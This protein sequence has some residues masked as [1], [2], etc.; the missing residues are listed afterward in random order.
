MP[1]GCVLSL[2]LYTL[3]THNCVPTHHSNKIIKFTD[4][5]VVVRFILRKEGLSDGSGLLPDG[6]LNASVGGTVTFRTNLDPTE[7]PLPFINWQFD[8]GP[9]LKPVLLLLTT[10]NTTAPE[11]EGRI[12]VFRSTGSLELRNLKL[13]DSGDYIVNIQPDGKLQVA[14]RTTLHIY[15]PVSSVSL[16]STSTDLIEF[17]SSVSLSCSSSGS[18]VSFLWMNSSSEVTASDR[19]QITDGGSTLTIVSVTRYD[20]GPYSC[21]VSNP[22][23]SIISDPVNFSVSYG[24]DDIQIEVAPPNEHHKKGSDIILTCSA[25]SSP[26]AEFLWFLN[27]GQMPDTGPE[28]KLMNIQMSQSG[29]YSCQAFNN[30]TLSYQ[31]SQPTAIFVHEPVFNVK[32]TQEVTHLIEFRGSVSFFCSSSG[33]SLSFLWMNSS[34]EVTASDRVQIT[35]GGSTLTIVNV[36]RD[37]QG[38]YSC[39]VSNPVSSASS[40]PVHLSVSYGP[41]KI[42][43]ISPSQNYKE[44]SN[45]TLSCSADSRPPAIFHWFLNGNLL[46]GSGSEL[47]LINV[48]RNQSGNYSCVAF[49]NI[50]LTNQTSQLLVISIVEAKGLSGGAIAAIT[51]SCLVVTALGAAGGFFIY[52]RILNDQL[53]R[54][55]KSSSPRGPDT[56]GGAETGEKGRGGEPQDPVIPG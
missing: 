9:V 18:S 3:Y 19:V 26:S 30:K 28:L 54:G 43:L 41:E 50:T 13:S 48:Q 8:S 35:D 6:P 46:P 10:G 16:S 56:G 1:Q 5:T 49:N 52:K 55:L 53:G 27:G 22:V 14:G 40:D 21:H 29:N 24:P 36:T 23:S 11:Y 2:L 37:D 44:G 38:P 32:V 20:Q 34:S 25:D 45:I 51:I 4:F 7:T 39:H 31:T 12:T 42:T 17:S 15:E 33:S 47:R